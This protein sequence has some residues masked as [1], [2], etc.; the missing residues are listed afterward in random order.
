MPLAATL[1]NRMDRRFDLNSRPSV[2]TLTDRTDSSIG[3]PKRLEEDGSYAT[4]FVRNADDYL[5]E[6][7]EDIGRDVG[8]H[9]RELFVSTDAAEALEIQ[10]DHRKPVYIVIHDVAA[11]ASLKM[12]A[13]VAA[14][15][16]RMGAHLVI[17][18]QGFGTT[19]ASIDYLDCPVEGDMRGLRLYSTAIDADTLTRVH[20]TRTLFRHAA[21][22]VVVVGNLPTHAISEELRTLRDHL[23]QG[24]N[25]SNWRCRDMLVMPLVVNPALQ[26]IVNELTAGTCVQATVTAPVKRPVDVWPILSAAWNKRQAS[27]PEALRGIWL[28]TQNDG[29]ISVTPLAPGHARP[30]ARMVVNPMDRMVQDLS[31]QPGVISCCLFE[32]ESSRV[33]AAAGTMHS[34]PDMARR[35]TLLLAAAQSGRRQLGLSAPVDE[36]VITGGTQALGLRTLQSQRDL[37]VHLIY[38][39]AETHWQ[40]LSQRIHKLDADLPRS[41]VI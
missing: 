20:L 38:T 35:G 28:D 25:P 30:V 3:T 15:V 11:K 29:M 8:N 39:P 34:G 2:P 36:V 9:T 18:R 19:L 5:Q 41:P 6:S 16:E 37:A 7:E 33:M 24:S 40:T 26:D 22:C 23:A 31:S 13:G 32:I 12:L 1:G 21:F 17:R 14:A 4:Q 10:F 27:L